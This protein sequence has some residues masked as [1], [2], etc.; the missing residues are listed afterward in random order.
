M[1]Y[2][3]TDLIVDR[4][5][6]VDEGAN[7]AAFIELYKRKETTNHMDFEAILGLMKPEHASV[8]KGVIEAKDADIAKARGDLDT[9][10]QNLAGKEVELG[11]ANE[12]LAKANAEI[13]TLKA[14]SDYCE[15]GGET[16]EDGKC[17]ACHKPKKSASF[18]ETETLK[19]MPEPMRSMFLKMRAQK[20]A[21]E[22][23]VRKANEEKAETAAVAKAASLKALPV[24]QS[25]LVSIL[26]SCTP[27]VADLLTTINA[28]IET[29]VLEEVGKNKGNG[30]ATG[31]PV[32]SDEAWQ[33]LEKKANDIAK[34]DGI[35]VEKAMG[36]AVSENPELYHKYLN[37]GA[38]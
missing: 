7:S 16:D 34:R 33:E 29:T 1:P 36:K 38:K 4:V 30:A 23:E 19:S 24:E 28:A 10:S 5:D 8:I 17:S 32:T 20:E 37:G 11:E 14:K 22:E 3:L 25:K 2:E 18:D 13:E 21:A 27:E 35:T 15:C 6:L 26:K 12:A 9:V 31:T